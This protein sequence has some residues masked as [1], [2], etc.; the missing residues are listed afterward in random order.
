[1]EQDEKKNPQQAKEKVFSRYQV[2]IIAMVSNLTITV[3]I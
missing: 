2:F 1:M 3:I